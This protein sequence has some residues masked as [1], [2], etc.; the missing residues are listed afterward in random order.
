MSPQLLRRPVTPNSAGR[1]G[2]SSHTPGWTIW[3][4]YMA[5][6][7]KD[8][9]HSGSHHIKVTA[10][11]RRLAQQNTPTCRLTLNSATILDFKAAFG[12][13]DAVGRKQ[14]Y[15]ETEELRPDCKSVTRGSLNTK[16]F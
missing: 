10:Q 12:F 5:K 14:K 15:K 1:G 4:Y 11:A 16:I 6:E 3:G 8:S 7:Q 2:S 9:E 13:V